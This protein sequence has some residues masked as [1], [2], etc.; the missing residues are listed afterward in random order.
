MKNYKKLTALTIATMSLFAFNVNAQELTKDELTSYV[1]AIGSDASY[2]YVIGK[3]AFT[4]NHNLTLEDMMLSAR[5]INVTDTTGTLNTDAVYGEMTTFKLEREFDADYKPGAFKFATNFTGTTAA[6]NKMDIEY[7]DYQKLNDFVTVKFIV[8]GND[9]ASF[10]VKKNNTTDFPDDPTKDG[11]LFDGWYDDG[12]NKLTDATTITGE[13]T[14]TARW[15][16]VKNTDTL[17]NDALG[18]MTSD[19]Y[20]AKFE[21]DKITIEILKGTEG[22]TNATGLVAS[23]REAIRTPEVKSITLKS[24]DKEVVLDD[25]GMDTTYPTQSVVALKLA[26]FLEEVTGKSYADMIQ[27]DL[28]GKNMT[29]TFTLEDGYVLEDGTKEKEYALEITGEIKTDY[30]AT[31]VDDLKFALKHADTIE[32]ITLDASIDTTLTSGEALLLLDGNKISQNGVTIDLNGNTIKTTG[33]KGVVSVTNNAKVAIFNGTI[34]TPDEYAVS[35]FGKETV[36]FLKDVTIK[37]KKQALSGNANKAF[38][39]IVVDGCTIESD[40]AAIYLPGI[41]RDHSDNA[42]FDSEG[43]PIVLIRNS[44]LTGITGIDM[45]TG[46]LYVESSNITATGSETDWEYV[47]NHDTASGTTDGSAALFLHSSRPYDNDGLTMVLLKNST[48]TNSN[49]SKGVIRLYE[50]ATP[51]VKDILVA[52][53]KDYTYENELKPLNSSVTFTKTSL[54]EVLDEDMKN[55]LDE[56]W[57]ALDAE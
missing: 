26:G 16:E 20:T 44:K 46:F 12:G 11:F 45:R 2:V 1:N 23:L 43:T 34:E 50:H 15:K 54:D 32:D 42:G 39:L 40:D 14:Y 36:L 55:M 37:S 47:K 33:G 38:G 9:F 31:S 21:N 24:G 48:L 29:V 8:D 6:P 25:D 52:S 27:N 18:K 30:T 19:V 13:T 41:N 57:K 28:I 7:V 56:L 17:V 10:V 3:Y 51:G 49:N 22:P 35:S 53:D 5:S 4:S